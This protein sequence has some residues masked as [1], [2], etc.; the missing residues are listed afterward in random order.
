MHTTSRQLPTPAFPF[1]AD[2]SS[3]LEG[4]ETATP[5]VLQAVA[6]LTATADPERADRLR[7]RAGEPAALVL[8]LAAWALRQVD[9]GTVLLAH[10][11]LQHDDAVTPTMQPTHC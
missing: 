6:L 10:S 9:A 8:R 2:L 11:M 7:P 4:R 1:L 3:R 5:D